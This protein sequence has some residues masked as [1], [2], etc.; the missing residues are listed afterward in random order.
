MKSKF[1]LILL[2]GVLLVLLLPLISAQVIFKQNSDIDLKVPCFFNGTYCDGTSE[3]S[4]SIIYPNG[5]LLINNQ[6]MGK[7]NP[8]VQ[9]I[10]LNDSSILGSYTAPVT[11]IQ[12]GFADD[13]VIEFSITPTGD[14]ISTAQGIIYLVVLFA[15]FLMLGLCFYGGLKIPF[16]NIRNDEGRIISIN[17]FKFIKILLLGLSYI[18]LM[19][20]FFLLKIIS[21]AFLNLGVTTALFNFLF[22]FMLSG[23]FPIFVIFI[24]F[25]LVLFLEDKKL[26]KAL[27]RGLPVR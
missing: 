6:T 26:Q 24:F 1:S 2:A 18:L 19:W 13:S 4:I 27:L 16:K 21:Q 20:V 9:N 17:D 22:W 10:T 11:C 7:L 15:S 12:S 14:E 5:T 23:L 8:G 25:A 3:C